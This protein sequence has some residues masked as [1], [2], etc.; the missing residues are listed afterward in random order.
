MNSNLKNFNVDDGTTQAWAE[1]QKNLQC[2]GITTYQDWKNVTTVPADSLPDSCCIN[3]IKGCG[4]SAMLK[5]DG[6][7]NEGGC[8]DKVKDLI[9]DNIVIV[10]AVA[11]A[12][13]VLQI[14]GICVVC[15]LAN[16][17]R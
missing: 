14:L 8:F 6:L 15:C 9:K 1:I 16:R 7:I 11:A 5:P 3:E 2:C 12:V 10:G 17:T 4:R 13:V